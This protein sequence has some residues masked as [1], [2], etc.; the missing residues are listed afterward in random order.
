LREVKMLRRSIPVL[1]ALAVV[2]FLITEEARAD[3]SYAVGSSPAPEPSAVPPDAPLAMPTEQDTGRVDVQAALK[4]M[5]SVAAM[6]N[7][8]P[9]S[10]RKL[11]GVQVRLWSSQ[12]SVDILGAVS[13][14]VGYRVSGE[15]EG[16][17]VSGLM[18]YSIGP[19][20]SGVGNARRGEVTTGLVFGGRKVCVSPS[21]VEQLLQ[22]MG[23]DQENIPVLVSNKADQSTEGY[24]YS[25]KTF[26]NI[27]TSYY[28]EGNRTC[29]VA[30]DFYHGEFDDAAEAEGHG[31]AFLTEGMDRN[32]AIEVLKARGYTC[33]KPKLGGYVDSAFIDCKAGPPD[34]PSTD[35]A[36]RMVELLV[37]VKSGAVMM[38]DMRDLP[39]PHAWEKP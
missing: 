21:A 34:P 30:L 3:N 39:P 6:Q 12:W 2:S 20:G 28:R 31:F 36:S 11:T 9:T 13:R 23:Y 27:R 8:G 5:A 35:V 1:T 14:S 17:P 38:A 26:P 10:L 16:V 32:Q 4:S 19:P 22:G 37:N 15:V 24:D 29:V 33:G 25:K 18:F 7:I